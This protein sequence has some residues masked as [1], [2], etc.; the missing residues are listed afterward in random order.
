MTKFIAKLE[1][2]VNS[3]MAIQ[4]I[5][6]SK[7]LNA[8][9]NYQ[10]W[11]HSQSGDEYMSMY[12]THLC[13]IMANCKRKAFN[14]ACEV[15][16]TANRHENFDPVAFRDCRHGFYEGRAAVFLYSFADVKEEDRHEDEEIPFNTLVVLL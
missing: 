1:D 14:W 6:K 16:A 5:N 9:G 7:L 12:E 13:L 4:A 15:A 11:E 3:L 2:A 8:N 10:L